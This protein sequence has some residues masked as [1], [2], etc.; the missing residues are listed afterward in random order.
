[1]PSVSN[2]AIASNP[3][4]GATS[5]DDVVQPVDSVAEAERRAA[6][7]NRLHRALSAAGL[8]PCLHRDETITV[9]L[10]GEIATIAI[11][12]FPLVRRR[13]ATG[14]NHV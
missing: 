9:G 13:R 2:G 5:L 8:C 3:A 6:I 14:V 12:T 10:D 4:T 11:D 7:L 1:M